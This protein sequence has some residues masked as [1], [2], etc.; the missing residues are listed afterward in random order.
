MGN[1]LVKYKTWKQERSGATAV[2][3]GLLAAGIALA[4]YLGV[5]MFG[6]NMRVMLESF[7]DRLGT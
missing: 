6:D 2:E 4:V 3:Y 5:Y 1:L 7:A